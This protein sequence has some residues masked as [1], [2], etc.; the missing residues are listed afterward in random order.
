ML[1]YKIIRRL[2]AGGMGEVY[3]A[4]DIDHHRKVAVKILKRQF[5]L[6]EESRVRFLREMKTCAELDHPNIIKVHDYGE[7]EGTLYFVMDYLPGK[8]LKEITVDGPLDLSEA[9]ALGKDIG[10]AL[11]FIHP[12]QLIHRDLKPANITLGANREAI[13]LDF[14]LVKALAEISLTVSGKMIGTP[15]YMAPEMML[16]G[17]VDARS[18]IYQLG[19]ILY[20]LVTA[21]HAV[22]G[23]TRKEVARR[24]IYEV[25]Q[26]P[27]ELRPEIDPSLENL[28]YNC[29]EKNQEHRYPS[30]VA[31]LEDLERYQARMPVPARGPRTPAREKVSK[32]KK[33]TPTKAQAGGVQLD[34]EQKDVDATIPLDVLGPNQNIRPV[35]EGSPK[36]SHPL[37]FGIL[38]G[39]ALAGLLSV[40]I[41]SWKSRQYDVRNFRVQPGYR[42]ATVRWSSG[43]PYSTRLLVSPSGGAEQIFEGTH[44]DGSHEV[45]IEGLRHGERTPIRVLFPDDRVGHQT[46]ISLPEVE[47]EEISRTALSP[48]RVEVRYRS[49]LP[50]RMR[51]QLYSNGELRD[52]LLPENPDAQQ[53]HRFEVS[54][55]GDGLGLSYQPEVYEGTQRWLPMGARTQIDGILDRVA[56]A[57]RQ[58]KDLSE[59]QALAG[60]IRQFLA[61]QAE[62]SWRAK[63]RL[64]A[65]LD[66]LRELDAR[67]KSQSKSLGLDL[68]AFFPA[69]YGPVSTFSG[70]ALGVFRPEGKAATRIFNLVENPALAS[71]LYSAEVDGAFRRIKERPIQALVLELVTRPSDLAAPC[72]IRVSIV[73]SGQFSFFFAKEIPRQSFFALDP[74]LLAKSPG[75]LGAQVHFECFFEE[76][77]PQALPR[78]QRP[79]VKALR[80]L[81]R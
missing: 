10:S 30:A 75:E 45:Q 15:R 57:L 81:G 66:E 12:R 49:N 68:A 61:N 78:I 5:A 63:G 39:F 42:R 65:S 76:S 53:R 24:S 80:F 74:R 34:G 4:E 46:E 1:K 19:C 56:R 47:L 27:S 6:S 18:D 7:S 52:F 64:L 43:V 31:F 71:D 28:I 17:K 9:V 70:E 14:G 26:A 67:A 38:L 72:A 77:G 41:R 3:L 60:P 69:N 37:A 21:T 55:G 33:A 2:G 35:T 8:N 44:E 40:G 13:L 51:L 58:G 59:I 62:V 16:T 11:A 79:T 32:A 20:E 48:T 50:L 25:P 29:L 23:K 36:K 73:E 22:P 54:L